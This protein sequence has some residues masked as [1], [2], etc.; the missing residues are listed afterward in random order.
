MDKTTGDRLGRVRIPSLGQYGLM[1][2]M[3]DGKQYI[4]MQV[5]RRLIALALP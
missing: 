5:S 1:S 2:Y 3:H 4:V